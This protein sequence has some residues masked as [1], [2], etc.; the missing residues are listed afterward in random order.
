[1]SSLIK[2]VA[3]MNGLN[4][5]ELSKIANVA[6]HSYRRYPIPKKKGGVRYILHPS[7][8][9]KLIQYSLI[10]LLKDVLLPH[11]AAK[12]FVRGIK[13]PLRQNAILHAKNSYYL[14]LDFQDF[15]PSIGPDDLTNTLE[16]ISESGS[17]NLTTE[18]YDFLAKA[19]FCENYGGGIGLPIG[20]PS[21]PLISN[22]VMYALDSEIE[23]L[24]KRKDFIYSRYA[25]DL[26]FSTSTKN[27]SKAF[28]VEIQSLI[29]KTVH[30]ALRIN[31]S[32]TRFMSRGSR[33]AI[34]GVI[35]TPEGAL[36]IG[37]K[38]KRKIRALLNQFRYETIT[39][40]E[41]KYLQ[42]YLAFVLDI[43][44]EFY[45]RLCQKYGAEQVRLALT[46]T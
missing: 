46:R 36:S 31:D 7:S 37:R 26:V 11:P 3:L 22:G 42:G 4:V 8:E 19:L 10:T 43:E 38:N 9:T 27:A 44:P 1:M 35:I 33:I 30:P 32:K 20:A 41:R 18:D 39:D 5:N 13:S 16:T 2:S 12:G 25:D 14:K 45:N 34:T 40:K 17:I 28:L 23:S 24:A 15:F 6:R 29:E 21:S